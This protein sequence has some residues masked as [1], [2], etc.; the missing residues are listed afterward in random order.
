MVGGVGLFWRF[1]CTIPCPL[2]CDGDGVPPHFTHSTLPEYGG[3]DAAQMA[4]IAEAQSGSVLIG[5]LGH[6]QGCGV[7]AFVDTLDRVDSF[8][9]LEYQR[10]FP[11]CAID[12]WLRLDGKDRPGRQESHRTPDESFR[13]PYVDEHD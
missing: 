8:P 3:R 10:H 5:V 4:S 2:H 11:A 13:G 7:A 1:H 6:S 12:S 9:L